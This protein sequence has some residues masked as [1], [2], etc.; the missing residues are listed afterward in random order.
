MPQPQKQQKRGSSNAITFK[1]EVMVHQFYRGLQHG[2][3]EML[4]AGHVTLSTTVG[5]L[6]EI[7]DSAVRESAD[8]T[9]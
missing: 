3:D 8:D 4:E 1:A 9:T 7:V 2:I 6:K 5:E